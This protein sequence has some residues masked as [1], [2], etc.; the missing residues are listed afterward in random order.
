M[1]RYRIILR[2]SR[3]SLVALRKDPLAQWFAL[4]AISGDVRRDVN[5]IITMLAVE[6][7]MS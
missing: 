2:A 5:A 7:I 1:R 6:D 3:I 4:V